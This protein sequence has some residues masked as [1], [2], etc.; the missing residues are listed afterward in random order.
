[1]FAIF[2]RLAHH[3]AMPGI[4]RV[5]NGPRWLRLPVLVTAAGLMLIVAA[6]I[7]GLTAATKQTCYFPARSVPEYSNSWIRD[8]TGCAP[9]HAVKQQTA[10]RPPAGAERRGPA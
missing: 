10:K 2:T 1:L 8:T 4:E 9:A 7:L 3:D 5:D 6:V